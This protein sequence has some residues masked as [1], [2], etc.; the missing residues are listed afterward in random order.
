MWRAPA[1]DTMKTRHNIIIQLRLSEELDQ[2]LD[3]LKVRL[4]G[5][6]GGMKMAKAELLRNLLKRG[7][8]DL[9]DELSAKEGH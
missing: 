5:S 9:E 3:D 4:E 7:I 6:C 8:Q 2:H 1:P